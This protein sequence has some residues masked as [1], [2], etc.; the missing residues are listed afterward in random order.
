M[1]RPPANPNKIAGRRLELIRTVYG[2]NHEQIIEYERWH[3]IVEISTL[4][5]LG[6]YEKE[7]I[8]DNKLSKIAECFKLELSEL[9]NNELSDEDFIKLVEKRKKALVFKLTEQI[10]DKLKD[11]G[12]PINIIDKMKKSIN[13]E[14]IREKDFVAALEKN[15]EKNEI[16]QYKSQILKGT[17]Y[18]KTKTDDLLSPKTDP[19]YFDKIKDNFSE[20]KEEI[21]AIDSSISEIHIDIT[22][23][24]KEEI[25]KRFN[26]VASIIEKLPQYLNKINGKGIGDFDD[27]AD[28]LKAKNENESDAFT[29]YFI[30]NIW[31]EKKK[32]KEA[33]KS[34][35]YVIKLEPNFKQAYLN[36]GLCFSQL[37]FLEKAIIDFDKCINLDPNFDLAYFYRGVF[38]LESNNFERAITDFDE[39]IKLDK[40]CSEAYLNRAFCFLNINDLEKFLMDINKCINIDPECKEAYLNRGLYYLSAEQLDDAI[41]DYSKY[42]ELDPN[43]IYAYLNRGLCNAKLNYFDDALDDFKKC[44]ELDPNYDLPYINSGIIYIYKNELKTAF[45]YY[46]IAIEKNPDQAIAYS[47][48]G[49]ICLL[50]NNL[51]QARIYFTKAIEIDPNIESF[52]RNRNVTYNLKNSEDLKKA[53]IDSDKA[54]AIASKK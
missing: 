53:I 1:A 23:T 54:R 20:I 52:Y 15:L 49:Y 46:N 9:I 21:K 32:Y 4:K 19:I 41:T 38:Y 45:D 17:K 29:H 43:Y 5:T 51:E 11:E 50:E 3:D 2:F 39:C 7:G 36:R 35:N 22:E 10:L 26:P 44:I 40:D 31:V 48:L 6:I 13:K 42:I 8:P 28:Y 34:Y 27:M 14:F 12:I 24:I 33:L 30:G 18:P 16:I 37:N 25:S 47:N